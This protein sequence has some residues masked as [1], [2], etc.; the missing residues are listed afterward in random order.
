[1]RKGEQHRPDESEQSPRQR[2]P[3]I[4]DAAYGAAFIKTL[5]A[6]KSGFPD[7]IRPWVSETAARLADDAVEAFERAHGKDGKP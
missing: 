7:M 3:G 5:D 6:P 1:M 4:W 2:Q